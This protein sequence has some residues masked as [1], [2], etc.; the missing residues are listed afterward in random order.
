MCIPQFAFSRAACPTAGTRC[1]TT[2]WQQAAAT[3][4]STSRSVRL[5]L[6]NCLLCWFVCL[7]WDVCSG[8]PF[9][10]CQTSCWHQNKCCDLVKA[11][12]IKTELLFWYQQEVWHNLN[13]HPVFMFMFQGSHERE[14]PDERQQGGPQ[15]EQGP[16]RQQGR[17]RTAGAGQR[18]S[19]G[20]TD[21]APLKCF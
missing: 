16:P 17:Q 4:W 19:H 7:F 12:H 13:D 11:P 9:R 20:E 6:S 3:L 21:R 18:G 10:F 2:T 5:Y 1:T 14:A 8:W 15:E